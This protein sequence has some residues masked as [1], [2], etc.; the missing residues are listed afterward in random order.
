MGELK[1]WPEK[2]SLHEACDVV[3][4]ERARAD[5]WEERCRV[6]VEALEAAYGYFC[7]YQGE[8]D[9]PFHAAHDTLNEALEGI[10]ELPDPPTD[11][12]GG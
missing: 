2:W 12:K 4:Y 9:G 10:G 11:S 3:A 6:A 7:H 5:C 8:V 1:K